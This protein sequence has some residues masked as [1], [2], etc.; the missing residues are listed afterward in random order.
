MDGFFVADDLW[1][2]LEVLKAFKHRKALVGCWTLLVTWL[3]S[4]KSQLSPTAC[5]Y[6]N[7]RPNASDLLPRRHRRGKQSVDAATFARW[8][9][10]TNKLA[11]RKPQKWPSG[12]SGEPPTS[13]KPLKINQ[14]RRMVVVIPPKRTNRFKPTAPKAGP[15]LTRKSIIRPTKSHMYIKTQNPSCS[16]FLFFRIKKP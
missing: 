12:P 16:V 8:T 5:C 3:P 15:R 13:P 4:R 6:A 11:A 7:K 10:P 14:N 1:S 2:R 9:P